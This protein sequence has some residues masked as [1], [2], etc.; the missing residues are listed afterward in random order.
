MKVAK[1][2]KTNNICNEMKYDISEIKSFYDDNSIH[3]FYKK[4][5]VYIA[6]IC[7][8]GKFYLCKF[9]KSSRILKRDLVEHRKTFGNQFRVICIIETDNNNV[10]EDIFKDSIKAKGLDKKMLFNG[11]KRDELFLTSNL[12]TLDNAKQTMQ[13]IVND[14]PLDSIK[15]RDNEIIKLKIEHEQFLKKEETKQT[16]LENKKLELQNKNLEIQNKGIELKNKNIELNIKFAELQKTQ[17]FD[18]RREI[19]Q[20]IKEEIKNEIREEDALY[21]EFIVECTEKVIRGHIHCTSLYN[22]FKKWYTDKNPGK[23]IPNKNEFINGI[24]N[25]KL[26]ENVRVEKKVQLG[27]KLLKLKAQYQ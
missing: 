3:K 22:G 18:Q 4:N 12:F 26:V 5:V 27:I 23:K 19:K 8:I 1:K 9:G 15:K 16:E 25:F 2:E 17:N 11:L 20:N 24:K 21:N 7:K 10:V 13:E 6:V 14:N